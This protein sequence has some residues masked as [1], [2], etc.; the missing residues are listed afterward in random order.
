V[1]SV[2]SR[3][4]CY[5]QDTWSNELVVGQL[6]AGKNM[7]TETEDIFEIRHQTTTGEDAAD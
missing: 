7:V 1:F 5:N 4:K 6:P 2:L 3:K